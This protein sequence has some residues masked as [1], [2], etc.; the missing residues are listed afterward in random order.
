MRSGDFFAV[1]CIE[2]NIGPATRNKEKSHSNP[3]LNIA[4]KIWKCVNDSGTD[5]QKHWMCALSFEFPFTKGAKINVS[6][7]SLNDVHE[8]FQRGIRLAIGKMVKSECSW[9]TYYLDKKKTD[10]LQ[11]GV[12]AFKK[13]LNIYILKCF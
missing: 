2:S 1:F 11:D 10:V 4:V 6:E 12:I 5:I 8:H 7:Q 13:C 9:T 3:S